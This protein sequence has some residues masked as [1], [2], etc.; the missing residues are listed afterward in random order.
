MSD[1]L[2]GI[3]GGG[4]AKHVGRKIIMHQIQKRRVVHPTNVHLFDWINYNVML[5]A[6]KRDLAFSDNDLQFIKL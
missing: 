1:P 2:T 4:K 3:G 6:T 5:K